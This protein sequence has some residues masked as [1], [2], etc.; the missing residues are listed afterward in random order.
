MKLDFFAWIEYFM[1][2]ERGAKVRDYV[3]G[4]YRGSRL[5]SASRRLNQDI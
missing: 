3:E 5:P 2:S 4:V 1:G